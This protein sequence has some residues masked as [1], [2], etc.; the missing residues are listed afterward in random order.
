MDLQSELEIYIS[1]QKAVGTQ[2][3]AVGVGLLLTAFI[4]HMFGEGPL[5][6]GLKIGGIVCGLLISGGGFLYRYTETTLLEN[7]ST[8]YRLNSE[9]FAL[10]EGARME[11]VVSDFPKYQITFRAILLAGMIAVLVTESP[12]WHGVSFTIMG[13]MIGV[14]IAEAFS[15]SSI[16]TYHQAL[17]N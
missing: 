1:A 16:M 9:K 12:F 8:L 17:L 5:A 14:L 6:S 15:K 7:Q 11:K 4:S 3:I 2:F 10:E 13:M